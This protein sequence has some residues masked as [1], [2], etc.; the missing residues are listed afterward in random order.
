MPSVLT[1][2][3]ELF[4]ALPQVF[5]LFPEKKVNKDTSSYK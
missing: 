2:L 1:L 4:L 5:S 3:P